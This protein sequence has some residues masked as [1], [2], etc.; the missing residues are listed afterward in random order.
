MRSTIIKGI[1]VVATSTALFE[2]S[3]FAS[4]LAAREGLQ[5]KTSVNDR[6]R[7]A[8]LSFLK[9]TISQNQIRLI[10]DYLDGGKVF[11]G[12]YSL[13]GLVRSASSCSDSTGTS[14]M[15]EYYCDTL[16][17]VC[18]LHIRPTEDNDS[19]VIIR[20]AI[21]K[22]RFIDYGY[23]EKGTKV[24]IDFSSETGPFE[25]VQV[26]MLKTMD[27]NRASALAKKLNRVLNGSVFFFER[28]SV[29]RGQTTDRVVSINIYV[30][31]GSIQ[32]PLDCPVQ[33]CK[34]L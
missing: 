2:S 15:S 7:S 16:K 31:K 1:A 28:E 22:T 17:D 3:V 4:Q 9:G 26:Y 32:N 27:Q 14:S 5:A 30:L 12:G 8:E 33:G 13:S 20:R 29:L 23:D 11:D 34:R 24:A 6:R 21:A 25:M 19:G 10:E 18:L